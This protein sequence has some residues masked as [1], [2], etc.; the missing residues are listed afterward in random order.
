MYVA[1]LALD[2][3]QRNKLFGEK[4]RIFVGFCQVMFYLYAQLRNCIRWSDVLRPIIAAFG[5][6]AFDLVDNVAMRC[7][8]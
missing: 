7:Q 3:A 6:F 2:S 4:S 1:E 8:L 5:V